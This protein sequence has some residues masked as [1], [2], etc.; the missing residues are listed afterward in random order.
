MGLGGGGKKAK[1]KKLD[2]EMEAARAAM[3]EGGSQMSISECPADW[4][5]QIA[6]RPYRVHTTDRT[7]GGVAV[8]GAR[9]VAKGPNKAEK[10]ASAAKSSAVKATD[11][12][13][14]GADK[15]GRKVG[16]MQ[17]KMKKMKMG[18]L[19]VDDQEAKRREKE[20]WSPQ[21]CAP[22][23]P[24]PC[25]NALLWTHSTSRGVP[26]SRTRRR[27]GKSWPACPRPCPRPSRPKRSRP[28][29]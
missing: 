18:K 17:R 3:K 8:D 5:V 19:E 14:T 20:V 21:Q 23:A 11:M 13:E 26:L 4:A 7:A 22:Q 27:T 15:S 28:A 24:M 9:K 25:T 1:K 6:C 12:A 10:G 29:S 2:A 16:D